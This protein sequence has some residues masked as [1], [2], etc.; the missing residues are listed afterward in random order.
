MDLK[1]VV[2]RSR[3]K[4]S[5]GRDMA[6]QRLSSALS[7]VNL[8][9]AGQGVRDSRGWTVLHLAARHSK[10]QTV[11]RLLD[12][13]ARVGEKDEEGNTPLHLAAESGNKEAARVLLHHGARVEDRNTA[14]LSSLHIAARAGQIS[15]ISLLLQNTHQVDHSTGPAGRTALHLAAG[16]GWFQVVLALL[17]AGA[18]VRARAT[19]GWTPLHFA[20]RG[21]QLECVKLLASRGAGLDAK[22]EAGWTPLMLA[23]SYN[24]EDVVRHLLSKGALA[25]LT[26][27]DGLTA[28]VIAGGKGL[29]RLAALLRGEEVRAAGDPGIG[30]TDD[31]SS[32]QPDAVHS[33][34]ENELR[35]DDDDEEGMEENEKVLLEQLREDLQSR[36]RDEEEA[37]EGR[38]KVLA[39]R[40]REREETRAQVGEAQQME[41]GLRR[42]LARV[43]RD[44]EVLERKEVELRNE[45]ATITRQQQNEKEAGRRRV[46]EAREKLLQFVSD[47]REKRHNRPSGDSPPPYSPPPPPPH[48]KEDGV[49]I[50]AELECPICLELSRPPIYQCPEGHIIC[51]QCRPKV[52]RC[53]VCRFVF[54]GTPAIRN[55]YIERLAMKY[56]KLS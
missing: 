42:E 15:T 36:L 8:S 14:G 34:N 22:T 51:S 43:A 47:Y 24:R 5:Q 2:R 41:D 29:A 11:R 25:R 18:S 56:F 1:A 40:Q 12:Q 10:P 49:D 28:E 9:G 48:D 30:Q 13:G 46:R 27:S 44:I 4:L 39:A 3:R 35:V 31:S 21:G 20:A 55:R 54:H 32:L 7:L 26:N 17:E 52:T 38:T 37:E 23:A 19:Q 16:Q 45:V 50:E 33:E 6:S 53:P